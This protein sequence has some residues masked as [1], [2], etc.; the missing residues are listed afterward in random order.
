MA[1]RHHEREERKAGWLRFEES[2]VDVTFEM[3]HADER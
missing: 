3:V 1:P 2:G